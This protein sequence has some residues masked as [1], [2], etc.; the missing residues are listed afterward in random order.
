MQ[1]PITDNKNKKEF[2]L[3]VTS[4]FFDLTQFKKEGN[5]KAFNEQLLK[6]MPHVKRYIAKRWHTA[7]TKNLIPKGKYKPDDFVDQLFIDAYEHFGQIANAKELHPWLFK[8]ADE[9]VNNTI[10]DEEF[11]SLF[12]ENIDTYSKPEWEEME[13]NFSTDGDGDL[14]M[15]EELDDLR[16]NKNDY[17]L[18]HVF[19]EDTEKALAVKLDQTLN[20]DRVGIHINMVLSKLPTLRHTVFDL[21]NLERFEVAEI[22]KIKSLSTEE[23]DQL[24]ADTRKLLRSSFSKRYL[25]ESN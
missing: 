17:T 21:F 18:N 13:E 14:V 19:V 4:A 6:I 11:D 25:M 10:I 23:V 12:F 5:R 8:K 1:D 3:F 16:L 22:A 15:L 2:H 24:L 7:L 9:L 20:K